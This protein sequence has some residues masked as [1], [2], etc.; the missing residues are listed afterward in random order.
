MKLPSDEEQQYLEDLE[1]NF[2]S[3]VEKYRKEKERQ[4]MDGRKEELEK[5]LRHLE[6]YSEGLSRGEISDVLVNI[7]FC[8]AKLR[9][10]R[11]VLIQ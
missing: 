2:D 1:K 5:E 4:L 10:L 11:E 7:R 8:R 3:Y 9:V 6:A